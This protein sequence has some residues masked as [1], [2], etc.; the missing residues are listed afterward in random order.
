MI[1]LFLGWCRISLLVI[2]FLERSNRPSR[3]SAKEP[4]SSVI[5]IHF[6][7]DVGW[8]GVGASITIVHI[9]KFFKVHQDIVRFRLFLRIAK[10]SVDIFGISISLLNGTVNL[11]VCDFVTGKLY[12]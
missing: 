9:R 1:F 11:I 8:S 2:G 7:T 6:Y 5:F 4:G 3:Y 12:L 10:R